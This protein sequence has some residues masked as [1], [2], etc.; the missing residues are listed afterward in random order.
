MHNLD[1]MDHEPLMAL[2]VPLLLALEELLRSESVTAAA[3]VLGRTQPSMSRTLTRLRMVFGDPLLVPVGRTMRLTPRAQELRPKVT[4]TLNSM[5]GLVAAPRPFSPKGERRV[6]RIAAADYAT[7]ILLNEWIGR[8][9][10]QA[11]GVSVDITPVDANS[12]D[13]LAR[14]ELDL[15]LGP[16]IPAVGLDQ[17]VAR[18]IAEDQLVCVVRRGHASEAKRLTLRAYLKLEHVMVGSVLPTVSTVD[19]ALRLQR[20]ARVVV[21]KVPSVLSA[22]MLVAV[23]D[24]AA[25]TY[26]RVL[27]YVPADLVARPLPFETESLELYLMWHPREN[28]DPFKRWIRQSLLEHARSKEKRAPTPEHS[29]RS[30]I[31]TRGSIEK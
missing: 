27:P 31:V 4:Q 5:R 20:T 22:L 21:A 30:A 13:P 19:M 28:A 17:F 1:A 14:G 12:I 10:K 23:S 8:V 2:D 15:A 26:A 24:Y 18:K 29:R 16:R 7:T 25:T 9:R 3:R 11:P 6:V